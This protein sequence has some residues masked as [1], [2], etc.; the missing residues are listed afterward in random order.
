M[1][2]F[3][4]NSISYSLYAIKINSRVTEVYEQTPFMKIHNVI[5]GAFHKWSP[6]FLADFWPPSSHGITKSR[7]SPQIWR[8]KASYPP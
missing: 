1:P 8:H 7:I 3:L 6:A 5:L 2:V 4:K